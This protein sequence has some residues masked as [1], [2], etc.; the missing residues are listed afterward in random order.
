MRTLATINF[1]RTRKLNFLSAALVSLLCLNCVKEQSVVGKWAVETHL[2]NGDTVERVG[3][4]KIELLE[5]GKIVTGSKKDTNGLW[6]TNGDFSKLIL[7]STVDTY[8][9]DTF[10]IKKLTDS[11]MVLLDRKSEYHLKKEG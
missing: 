6:S 7:E 9:S 3:Q 11:S 4:K 10:T 2:I 8:D 5:N 1:M